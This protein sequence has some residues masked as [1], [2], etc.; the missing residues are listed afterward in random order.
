MQTN[1][2][3][4]EPLLFFLS[5]EGNRTLEY[6]VSKIPYVGYLFPSDNVI[7][8]RARV[9]EP[10][11]R[12]ATVKELLFDLAAAT[13][14]HIGTPLLAISLKYWHDKVV[15]IIRTEGELRSGLPH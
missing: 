1:L 3:R 9:P 2:Y 11:Y 10:L 15:I 5:E 13:I 7:Y 4:I 6:S 8:L 14:R 12:T